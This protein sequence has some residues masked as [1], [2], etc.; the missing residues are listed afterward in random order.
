[1]H[2]K[3]GTEAMEDLFDDLKEQVQYRNLHYITVFS[4]IH[5]N[6]YLQMEFDH[7]RE[8]VD[9]GHE[10]PCIQKIQ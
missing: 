8:Y 10:K 3:E 9:T 6:F 1:M 4:Y 2:L 5:N 7:V